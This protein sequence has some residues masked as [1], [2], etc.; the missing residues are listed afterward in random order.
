MKTALVLLGST[1]SIGSQ[2][3]DVLS[4]HKDRFTVFALTANSRWQALAKQC[5]EWQPAYAAMVDEQAALALRNHL[6]AQ[7]SQTQVLVGHDAVCQLAAASEAQMVVA[8]IV[9][10]AGVLPSLAAVNAGKRVLLANK[11]ALVVTGSLFMQAVK[12]HGATLLRWTPSTVLF[13][14]VWP[15]KLI[16]VVSKS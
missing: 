15:V 13:F 9:G 1:G 3:L 10:A 14:S 11:E 7:G 8:A 5:L 12:A 4:R 2:T 6:Q 16:G